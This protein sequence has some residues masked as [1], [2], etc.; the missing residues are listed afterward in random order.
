MRKLTHRL[1]LARNLEP[2]LEALVRHHVGIPEAALLI[3]A[4]LDARKQ[5]MMTQLQPKSHGEE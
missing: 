3:V 5:A 4:H 2:L 1:E